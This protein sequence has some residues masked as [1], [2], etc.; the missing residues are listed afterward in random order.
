MCYFVV[1]KTYYDIFCEVPDP[2]VQ[3]RCLHKLS[4]ILF[5]ALCTLLSNGE[6]FEDM[7]EFGK[8]RI[9]WLEEILELP[10]GIPSHDTFNRCLQMIDPKALTEV[11]QEDGGILI[12]GLKDKL[13]A[14]DGKKLKGESPTSLGNQGLYLLNAWVCENGICIGQERVEDKSNEITAIPKL[15]SQLDITGSTVSIDAMGCQTEVAELI[16]TKEADYLLAVKLNQSSLHEEIE[17]SFSFMKVKDDFQWE[18]D[19]GRYETRTCKLIS[20]KEA[21]SP[22][23]LEKWKDVETIVKI[24]SERTIKGITT[25]QSRYYI[26][27]HSTKSPLEF[28]R[29]VRGHWSIENQLHWHLDITFNEDASRVRTKNAPINLSIIRKIALHRIKKMTDKISLKKRRFRA[30]LN[31]QYL[32]QTLC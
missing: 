23:Q 24:E 28:N 17:E 4:D 6:D 15:L 31:N 18:Y 21:L 13:V 2:R 11:L 16:R 22:I 19:H 5:I 9:T 30:S 29:M 8:Q 26:S 25:K 20:A 10:N 7:V 12:A 14:I 1:M 27:S 32:I 3:G